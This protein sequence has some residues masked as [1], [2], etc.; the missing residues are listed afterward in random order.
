MKVVVEEAGVATID[1][2]WIITPGY[3]LLQ[4]LPPKR[5]LRQVLFSLR[6]MRYLALT[7]WSTAALPRDDE[8]RERDR[9]FWL[10]RCCAQP[11]LREEPTPLELQEESEVLA[12]AL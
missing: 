2:R 11:P 4:R 7:C 5:L 12:L 9:S 6:S 1:V 3:V 8:F 10:E